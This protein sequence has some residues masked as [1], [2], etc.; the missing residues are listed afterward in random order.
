M[1]NRKP[2][3][4]EA[5]NICGRPS[6]TSRLC[7]VDMVDRAGPDIRGPTFAV[8]DQI[9]GL[10][11]VTIASTATNRRN[12][13]PREAAKLGWCTAHVTLARARPGAGGSFAPSSRAL[14]TAA[15]QP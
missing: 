9:R 15:S 4:L 10:R 6:N 2:K 12:A 3:D 13:P 1:R 11:R 14:R 5:K 8:G 7:V